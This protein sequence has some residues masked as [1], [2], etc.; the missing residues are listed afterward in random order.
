LSETARDVTEYSNE[1]PEFAAIAA[2]MVEQWETG[3]RE[4]LTLG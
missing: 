4:S 1:H 3:I 2:R